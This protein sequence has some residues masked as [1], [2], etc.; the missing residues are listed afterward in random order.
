MHAAPHHQHATM[1]FFAFSGAVDLNQL[2]STSR[3][4]AIELAPLRPTSGLVEMP[5]V[6]A[7]GHPVARFH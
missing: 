6:D 4:L 1:R 5:V 7:M 3:L 2:F